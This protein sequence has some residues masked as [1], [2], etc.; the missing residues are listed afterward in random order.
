MTKANCVPLTFPLPQLLDLI[1]PPQIACSN[2]FF[3]TWS[4]NKQRTQKFATVIVSV[5]MKA[6]GYGQEGKD[7]TLIRGCER[8]KLAL[9]ENGIEQNAITR[10]CEYMEGCMHHGV[11]VEDQTTCKIPSNCLAENR[12]RVQSN[13]L[14]FSQRILPKGFSQKSSPEKPFCFSEDFSTQQ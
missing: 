8:L 1:L 12:W 13:A 14:D 11:W 9:V 3:T 5:K 2:L 10:K 4:W 6:G 7:H